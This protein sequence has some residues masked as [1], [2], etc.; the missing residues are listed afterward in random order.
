M[1]NALLRICA[2]IIIV[3]KNNKFKQRK[4]KVSEF[5]FPENELFS[6]NLNILVS[7]F[8]LKRGVEM[9]FFGKIFGK[10]KEEF[11]FSPPKDSDL[12]LG[13]D[14]GAED[15]TAGLGGTAEL[16]GPD[17]RAKQ[18][19][20]TLEPVPEQSFQQ[21]RQWQPQPSFQSHDSAYIISKNLEVIS[22]KL[23]ALQAAIE[24]LNQRLI[25]LENYAR[26]EQDRSKYRW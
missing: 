13:A 17:T 26:G 20:P 4:L 14:F 19:L 12:G 3:I 22:S 15:T 1:I 8:A 9:G 5:K 7:N 18:P 25:N 11:D 10:K 24:S 16:A 6:I 2:N 21:A 23:D